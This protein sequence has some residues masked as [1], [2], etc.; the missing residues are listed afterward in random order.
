MRCCFLLC[1]ALAAAPDPEAIETPSLDVLLVSVGLHGHA[2]PLARLAHQ[3]TERGHRATLATHSTK[4]ARRW[5]KDAGAE[6]VSLGVLEPSP[7]KKTTSIN[8]RAAGLMAAALRG[9]GDAKEEK[10]DA[11]DA[12]DDADNEEEEGP[13]D[14]R[15]LLLAARRARHEAAARYLH[16][17]QNDSEYDASLIPPSKTF[18]K[19]SRKATA[20]GAL[21]C[22][23]NELYVPLTRP[24]STLCI[25]FSQWW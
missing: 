18:A 3:L 6:F 13:L 14:A 16:S 10:K 21:A 23:M 19:A 15:R 1:A 7:Q 5:A 8:E 9:F 12:L 24:V 25:A 11:W 20:L 4:E 17:H 2:V 22:L